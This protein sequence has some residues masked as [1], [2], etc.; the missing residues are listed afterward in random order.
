MTATREL[1][2][3]ALCRYDSLLKS[4]SVTYCRISVLGVATIDDDIPGLKQGNLRGDTWNRAGKAGLHT[5]GFQ[6]FSGAHAT[7]PVYQ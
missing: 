6:R 7:P 3:N 2:E 5:K 1:R 4:V